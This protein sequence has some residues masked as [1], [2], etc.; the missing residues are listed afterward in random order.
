MATIGRIPYFQINPSI[1]I[2]TWFRYGQFGPKQRSSASNS[3]CVFPWSWSWGQFRYLCD[4]NCGSC[5]PFTSPPESLLRAV[6][7]HTMALFRCIW[8]PSGAGWEN[9]HSQ[10]G[11]E[12]TAGMLV[13]YLS[14]ARC[15]DLELESR[16]LASYF[17]TIYMYVCMH[18]CMYVCV[19]CNV[20]NVSNVSNVC[21]V[22][23][24]CMHACML[25]W[26]GMAW[27]GMVWYVCNVCNAF[28]VWNTW[29]VM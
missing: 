26:H 24:V 20:S 7:S 29:N 15:S 10:E 5:P 13:G 27:H 25:A 28:H 17:Y 3:A 18:V 11:E 23:N 12:Q 16:V 19:W 2:S 14:D 6:F 22:C 1:S 4:C 21:N 8:D 9:T